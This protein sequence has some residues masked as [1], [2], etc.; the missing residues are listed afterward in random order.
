MERIITY[1]EILEERP[2]ELEELTKMS[3]EDLSLIENKY[4]KKLPEVKKQGLPK[5]RFYEIE[6]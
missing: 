4:R 5:F 1:C 6:F 2:P 3:H